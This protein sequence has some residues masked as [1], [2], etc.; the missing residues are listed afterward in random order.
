MVKYENI[1]NPARR[2]RISQGPGNLTGTRPITRLRDIDQPFQFEISFGRR[3][4]E[5]VFYDTSSPESWRL[6]NPDLI[7]LCYDI[8]QRSSLTNLQRVWIREVR[9]EFPTEGILPLAVLGL[10]RDLRVEDDP[11]GTIYPQEAT[12]VASAIRADRY[13]ECS[14]VTGELLQLAFEEICQMAAMTSTAEGGQ[15]AGGCCV[16]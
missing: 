14:A 10:K 4:Y 6:L 13:A 9:A 2:R 7:I 8:S 12:A 15:S 3:R 16:M 5:L 11:N 1:A